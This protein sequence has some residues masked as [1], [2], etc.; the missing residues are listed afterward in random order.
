MGKCI[1]IRLIDLVFKT[2]LNKTEFSWLR[3]E[4]WQK[5]QKEV[6]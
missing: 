1:K 5:W 2:I 4:S 6:S 3:M